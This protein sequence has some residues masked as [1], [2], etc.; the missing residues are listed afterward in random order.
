MYLYLSENNVVALC[1]FL[2]FYECFFYAFD[3][4]RTLFLFLDFHP[5]EC[6]LTFFCFVV[7]SG[8]TRHSKEIQFYRVYL[9]GK[10]R[11]D[12]LSH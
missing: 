7:F 5:L 11:R 10:A 12:I 6:F 9:S 8:R 2:S 1:A 3:F 4:M